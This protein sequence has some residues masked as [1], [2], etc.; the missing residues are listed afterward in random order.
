MQ[1]PT[2]RNEIN[3][4]ESKYLLIFA[5]NLGTNNGEATDRNTRQR[6][7]TR[8]G[9]KRAQCHHPCHLP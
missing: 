4:E 1:K 7:A 6:I 9:W 8:H 2:K 5:A 3:L